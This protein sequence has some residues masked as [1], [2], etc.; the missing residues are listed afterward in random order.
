MRAELESISSIKLY[1]YLAQMRMGLSGLRSHLMQI[2]V[3]ES[4]MC[5]K[6]HSEVEDCCH[7]LLRCDEYITQRHELFRDIVMI[8]EPTYWITRS[9]EN[10]T[11]ILLY[12]SDDFPYEIAFKIITYIESTERFKRIT[13]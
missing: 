6:C 5:E 9:E 3:T 13:P 12:S 1:L 10:I 8:T 11:K 4:A 7:F 2:K